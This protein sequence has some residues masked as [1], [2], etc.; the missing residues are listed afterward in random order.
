MSYRRI[1]VERESRGWSQEYVGN[2][3]G[4]TKQSL[5]AIERGDTTPS[6][7]VLCDL[8]RLFNLS[9]RDLLKQVD[10]EQDADGR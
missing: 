5:S 4:I 3:I 8:E 7:K 6:Y 9:H 10:A 1:R 2:L